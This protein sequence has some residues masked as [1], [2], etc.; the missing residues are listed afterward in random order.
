MPLFNG[1]LPPAVA[2][3]VPPSFHTRLVANPFVIEATLGDVSTVIVNVF[4]YTLSPAAGAKIAVP[5]HHGEV[6]VTSDQLP[7]RNALTS[8]ILKSFQVDVGLKGGLDRSHCL[9]GG[10]VRSRK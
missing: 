6:A 8:A 3:A 1:K 4:A 9:L 5:F 2:V 7:D 10:F